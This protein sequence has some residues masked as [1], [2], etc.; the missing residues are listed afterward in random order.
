M[1]DYELGPRWR[2]DAVGL[3][4]PKS[5]CKPY[6]LHSRCITRSDFHQPE[7]IA[8][9]A[10]SVL[11]TAPTWF[12]LP[13]KRQPRI[14]VSIGGIVLVGADNKKRIDW[15]LGR[16]SQLILGRD[17]EVRLVRVQTSTNELLCP[18]QRIYPLEIATSDGP[19]YLKSIK[20][21]DHSEESDQFNDLA[22]LEHTPKFIEK[23]P[24]F[25]YAAESVSNLSE[26]LNQLRRAMEV[27]RLN[28]TFPQ[29]K[30]RMLEQAEL[31]ATH[32]AA[33]APEKVVWTSPEDHGLLEP[34]MFSFPETSA[35]QQWSGASVPRLRS[36]NEIKKYCMDR[37]LEFDESIFNFKGK[38]IFEGI[39]NPQP[40]VSG[41][42]KEKVKNNAWLDI[43]IPRTFKP[44]E[45]S[46]QQESWRRA[47]DEE[48]DN[49]KLRN[50]W[51][52]TKLPLIS[53]Y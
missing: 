41:V 35:E 1:L 25:E 53:N 26:S 15:P 4:S 38:D 10:L 47:M 33:E 43:L 16:I 13:L 23:V 18:I 5:V 39:I 11:L 14:K 31:E 48:S 20:S 32:I 27:A 42:Q 21:M 51:K 24:T 30:M 2:H 37:K 6:P 17:G 44:M 3:T 28:K 19:Q 46:P 22:I 49:L 9:T 8:F 40:S 34:L 52:L 7:P 50:V 29:A 45:K 36:C 12:F